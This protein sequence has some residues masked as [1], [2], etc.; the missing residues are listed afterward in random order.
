MGMNNDQ[1]CDRRK[2]ITRNWKL[3]VKYQANF[4]CSAHRIEVQTLQ[5]GAYKKCATWHNAWQM[6]TLWQ[7]ISS[8]K[9]IWSIIHWTLEDYTSKRFVRR[10]TWNC[11]PFN[12]I[13]LTPEIPLN[14]IELDRLDYL[15]SGNISIKQS[16]IRFIKSKDGKLEGVKWRSFSDPIH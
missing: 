12:H 4:F 6:F 3:I 5:F 8:I 15:W 13:K 16:I 11:I 9:G 1:N 10:W 2:K 7:M 14:P